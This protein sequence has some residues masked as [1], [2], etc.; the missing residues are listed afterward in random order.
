MDRRN[1]LSSILAGSTFGFAGCT[2]DSGGSNSPEADDESDE[3]NVSQVSVSAEDH[4]NENSINTLTLRY[5]TDTTAELDPPDS[6]ARSP[7]SGNKLVILHTEVEVNRETEGKIDV[8]GSAIGLEA[9]G[10]MYEGRSIPNL[11]ELTQTARP[12]ATYEAWAQF[13]V[14][15]DVTEATLIA[16]D[17]GAWFD[18][19]TQILFERDES[20][21]STI[22]EGS[23]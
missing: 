21:S 19:P 10:V 4:G 9:G 18:S 14:P 11:P 15:E 1:V 3:P 13:E 12:E 16:V 7:D 8:Y 23:T 6:P 17:V 5:A 2:G 22:P 20:R